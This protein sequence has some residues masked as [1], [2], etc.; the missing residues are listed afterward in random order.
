MSEE[1][2]PCSGCGGKPVY[3]DVTGRQTFGTPANFCGCLNDDCPLF[4]IVF[5][6]NAWNTRPVEDALRAEVTRLKGEYERAAQLVAEMHAAVGEV[7]G[8]T[9]GVVE[10]V[11]DLRLKL[12]GYKNFNDYLN[13]QNIEVAKEIGQLR[14]ELQQARDFHPRAMKLIGKRKNFIVI[15]E[16]EPYFVDAYM[17]IRKHEKAKGRW[18]TEDER[19]YREAFTR[20]HK[21]RFDE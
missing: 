5:A 11:R 19:R 13:R 9:R 18:T 6:V 21:A 15:A 3:C 16:D 2:K 14:A 17:E 7:R 20:W 1:L 8:P 10:D 4:D 12:Q